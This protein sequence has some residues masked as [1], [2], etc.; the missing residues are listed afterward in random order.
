[1]QILEMHECT[2]VHEEQICCN[3]AGA[4]KHT[5]D[6]DSRRGGSQNKGGKPTGRG[7][8]AGRLCHKNNVIWTEPLSNLHSNIPTNWPYNIYYHI[9]MFF[10]SNDLFLSVQKWNVYCCC[11]NFP[12]YE[13]LIH[14][15]KIYSDKNYVL[16]MYTW[17]HSFS[18]VS[19]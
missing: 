19:F 15:L 14:C 1:M 7:R 16:Y 18:G 6:S 17:I 2:I 4:R 13:L 11:R 9:F 12:Q 5:N 8:G 10:F 3:A